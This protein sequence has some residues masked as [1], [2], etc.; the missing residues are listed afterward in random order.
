MTREDIAA[1]R[2]SACA[3]IGTLGSVLDSLQ[4][5]DEVLANPGSGFADALV[6]SQ[7]LDEAAGTADTLA[8]HASDF[9]LAVDKHQTAMRERAT[10]E[11]KGVT[12]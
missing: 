4:M 2:A 9:A 7:H 11:E 1:L 3:M 8:Q 10:A 5:V 6:C 12:S